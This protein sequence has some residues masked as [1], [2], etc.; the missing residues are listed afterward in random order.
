MRNFKIHILAFSFVVACVV[1]FKAQAAPLCVQVAG[2]PARCIYVDANEC[3]REAFRVGGQCAGNPAEFPTT[4]VGRSQFCV[5]ESNL[6]MSCIYPDRQSCT[7]ESLR[8]G[9]AC[10]TASP[11]PHPPLD[12]YEEKRPYSN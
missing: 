2:I 1:G 11:R 9:G 5:V 6:V 8:R 7:M 12:P 3:Q 4:A 10:V